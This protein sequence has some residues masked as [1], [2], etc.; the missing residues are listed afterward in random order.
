[1]TIAV[2]ASFTRNVKAYFMTLSHI[3][4]FH[5]FNNLTITK[6]RL[7]IV[8]MISLALGN[9]VHNAVDE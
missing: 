8:L 3:H 5:H 4:A 2:N 9:K 6:V 1:M 7:L